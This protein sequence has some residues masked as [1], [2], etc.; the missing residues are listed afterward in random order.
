MRKSSNPKIY[1]A[2]SHKLNETN[3]YS[4]TCEAS[5]TSENVEDSETCEPVEKVIF[6][7]VLCCMVTKS[8]PIKVGANFDVSS[9]F[10]K[11]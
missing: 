10:R 2:E 11:D 4:E 9:L 1:V 7:S 5:E 3:D 6:L 8:A